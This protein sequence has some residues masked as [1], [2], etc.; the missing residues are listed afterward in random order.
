MSGETEES[1]SGW[2][3][4]TLHNHMQRQIDDMRKML[5]ERYQTQT[6]A[7]DAAFL[8]QQ[9]A[10]TTALAAAERA[11][12]TALQSAEKAVSKAEV[13]QEKR[14][15]SV[16]EFRGQLSD[17]AATFV[18]RDEVD[19]RITS[20]NER[21]TELSSRIDLSQGEHVGVRSARTTARNDNTFLIGAVGLVLT[22]IAVA[23]A[24]IVAVAR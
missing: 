17:Q 21:V 5:D 22:I 9:T 19:I 18:R 23:T 12:A 1:V 16:N 8:A 24:V 14:L 7:V 3:V 20:L 4:D 11:V 6:K 10:M 15:E 13:A 2:T